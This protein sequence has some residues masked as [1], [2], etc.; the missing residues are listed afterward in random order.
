M[1]P[2][3]LICM[4]RLL[5]YIQSVYHRYINMDWKRAINN[6]EHPHYRVYYTVVVAML[7]GCERPLS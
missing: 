6:F 1:K 7:T 5:D 3:G 2:S 4:L